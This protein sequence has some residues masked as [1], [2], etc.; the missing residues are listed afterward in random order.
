MRTETI[1]NALQQL[2]CAAE[3]LGTRMGRTTSWGRQVAAELLRE[4]YAFTW[5][6]K[7]TE[8][9][10]LVPILRATGKQ[11]PVGG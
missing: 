1:Q 2:P 9:G 10:T 6:D 4:R 8:K 11:P 3:E 7:L 5:G